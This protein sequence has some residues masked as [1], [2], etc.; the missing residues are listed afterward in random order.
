MNRFSQVAAVVVL[1][2][3]SHPAEANW[4]KID[5]LMCKPAVSDAI[6]ACQNLDLNCP[7]YSVQYWYAHQPDLNLWLNSP[8]GYTNLFYC[9]VPDT[10][11]IPVG[12]IVEYNFAG[13][14]PTNSG[15]GARGC[16]QMSNWYTVECQTGFYN[17][18]NGDFQSWNMPIPSNWNQWWNNAYVE[19]ILNGT[20]GKPPQGSGGAAIRRIMVVGGCAVP[21]TQ[22]SC[23][24]YDTGTQ[25]SRNGHNW[26]CYNANCRNCAT[27][28]SCAPGGSGC[29]WG[30]VWVD[31]GTCS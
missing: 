14:S 10:S 11:A 19:V 15:S 26:T 8:T 20:G 16:V 18:P 1:S 23:L 7:A 9:P 21:Y 24:Y 4:E 22:N 5:P 2:I 28:S 3:F 25:V 13:Y 6:L 12:Q 29:P 30:T 31:N 17:F 27:Y